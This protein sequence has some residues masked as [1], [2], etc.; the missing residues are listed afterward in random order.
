M[1][2]Q[3]KTCSRSTCLCSEIIIQHWISSARLEIWKSNKL[4]WESKHK[5]LQR[6]SN[7]HLKNLI[8]IQSVGIA[9]CARLNLLSHVITG[10][11]N[12]VAA[13]LTKNPITEFMKRT[14][15]FPLNFCNSTKVLHSF[16]DHF[17]WHLLLAEVWWAVAVMKSLGGTNHCDSE[18]EIKWGDSSREPTESD[19]S[20]IP[21]AKLCGG[22]FL[23]ISYVEKH[24]LRAAKADTKEEKCTIS[25]N[26]LY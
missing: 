7:N 2:Q 23:R 18:V 24:V 6:E 15:C 21:V 3:V 1:M 16:T 12:S 17:R 8:H 13:K 19:Q 22:K 25:V 11:Q 20:S 26:K 5:T 9:I 10:Q 14:N 4:D